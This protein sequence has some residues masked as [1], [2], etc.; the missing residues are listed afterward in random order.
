M[1]LLLKNILQSLISLIHKTIESLF[2][3]VIWWGDVW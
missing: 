3:S 2:M 1:K